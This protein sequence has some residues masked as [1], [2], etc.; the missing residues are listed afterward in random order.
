MAVPASDGELSMAQDFS[1]LQKGSASLRQVA[2]TAMPQVMESK[3]LDPGDFQ[4]PVPGRLEVVGHVRSTPRR[5]H[6]RR[7]ASG[8]QAHLFNHGWHQ[9]KNLLV[10]VLAAMHGGLCALE[11]DV[12]PTQG[13]KFA[14]SCASRQR[15]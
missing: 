12:T 3:L 7:R 1:N 14:A 4:C 11:I 6:E 15:Q 10:P 8:E 13:L 5:K 2:G 9:G